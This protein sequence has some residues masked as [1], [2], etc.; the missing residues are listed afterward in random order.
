LYISGVVALEIAKKIA[1]SSPEWGVGWASEERQQ[2]FAVRQAI[3]DRTAAERWENE[4]DKRKKQS[5]TAQQEG[6]FKYQNMITLVE[7]EEQERVRRE[8]E[9]LLAQLQELRGG[10]PEFQVRLDALKDQDGN[11]DVAKAHRLIVSSPQRRTHTQGK[12]GASGRGGRARA[13]SSSGPRER[14]GA[15]TKRGSEGDS[16][17]RNCA[18]NSRRP[19]SGARRSTYEDGQ[20]SGGGRSAP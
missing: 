4:E 15:S 2:S 12:V 10:D 19:S 3:S 14:R 18:F 20:K 11:I 17:R 9:A 1:H 7:P 5:Q 8:Q 6:L 13:Q 16:M